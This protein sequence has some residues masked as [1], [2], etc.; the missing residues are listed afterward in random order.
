MYQG[1]HYRGA[2]SWLL[3]GGSAAYL[4]LKTPEIRS[5]LKNY[6]PNRKES[7]SK[8][9]LEL[10]DPDRKGTVADQFK[11]SWTVVYK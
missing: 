5:M 11:T 3:W 4:W 7:C 8:N 10:D 1:A 6:F 9:T 2:V